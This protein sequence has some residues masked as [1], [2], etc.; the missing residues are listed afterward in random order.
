MPLFKSNKEDEAAAAAKAEADAKAAADAAAAAAAE[1]KYVS[2]EEFD[3]M[4]TQ[5]TGIA[6]KL[7][8][9]QTA[10]PAY[11][12]P[13]VPVAPV[14]PHKEAKER[15]VAID[16]QLEDL[17]KKMDD[18]TY[19]GKGAGEVMAQQNR[20]MV[21]RS[22]LVGQTL[23]PSPDAR[24][25]AGIQT[26]DAL[27]TEITS[28]KMPHLTLPEVKNSYERYIGQLTPEQRMNPQAKMGA[29]NL[30]V[31]ENLP[32]IEEA[33]KQVWLREAEEIATQDGGSP[34]GPDG[35]STGTTPTPAE[36]LSPEALRSIKGSRHRSPENYYRSLG[37]EGWDDYYE[38]NK[39]YLTEEE[40]E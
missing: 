22:T 34:P 10:Q 24:M 35:K 8:T 33:Q 30:A 13:T 4:G 15:I 14:D 1:P 2:K 37:Y 5:L 40:G 29:Y 7:E 32:K 6:Q 23:I 20:L 18:A 26:L 28:G 31:G 9:L 36:V 39:E 19:A 16:T 17:T 25:E 21:E 11:Q 12:Q 27:S 38:K 3:A